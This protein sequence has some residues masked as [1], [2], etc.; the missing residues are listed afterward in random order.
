MRLCSNTAHP[1]PLSVSNYF[2][3][4]SGGK[5]RHIFKW[6][7]EMEREREREKE[8]ERE[9]ERKRNGRSLAFYPNF[10]PKDLL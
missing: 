6:S 7:G 1:S 3:G 8:R 10:T 9:R 5:E 2:W 4:Q